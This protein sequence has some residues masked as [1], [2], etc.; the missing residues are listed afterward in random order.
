M[1]GKVVHLL[2]RE[3]RYFARLVVPKDVRP[4]LDGKSE[5]RTALGPDRRT[6]LA[7]LPGAVA[8]LQYAIGHAEQ[9]RAAATRT[10]TKPARYPL[11]V[12]EMAHR[13]YR[14]LLA[15]DLE[16]REHD[17][18]YANTLIDM[19]DGRPFVDGYSGRLT[20]DELDAL[21]GNRIEQFRLRGHTD[22]V[23]GTPEWRSLAISFCVAEFEALSRRAERNDGDFAGKPSRAGGAR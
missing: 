23:K 5:L 11:S 15:F 8:D 3:G 2:N 1:A 14:S 13:Q 20:D 12:E 22:F 10:A 18:R 21:V 6:A 19:D 16:I 9:R 4:F 17:P 7:R